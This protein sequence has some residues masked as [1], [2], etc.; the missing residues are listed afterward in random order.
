VDTL[1][2]CAEE[3]VALIERVGGSRGNPAA[4]GA[5]AAIG[6]P[7]DSSD[8]RLYP[9][10]LLVSQGWLLFLVRRGATKLLVGMVLKKIR[11]VSFPDIMERI[12]PGPSAQN[13]IIYVGPCSNANALYLQELVAHLR[14]CRNPGRPGFGAGDR[15]G[16][17][18]PGHVRALS[19][20][21]Y[22]PV[23][24]QQSIR[25]MDR[26]AR[27]PEDVMATAV[28]GMFQEGFSGAW[29]ADADHLKIVA[30]VERVATCPYTMF[31]L[32]PSD[33]IGFPERMTAGELREA[34]QQ[35][36]WAALGISADQLM[37]EYVG[38]EQAFTDRHGSYSA[39][40]RFDQD[41]VMRCAVKYGPGVA[42]CVE[43]AGRLQAER[44]GGFDLE[45]SFDETESPTSPLEHLFLASEFRR[46][47]VVVDS[48]ALRF[49]GGFEKGIDY[50]GDA[51][52]FERAFAV[53][54]AI[55]DH[56]GR[57]R[58][59]IHSG[60]DKF[61]IYPTMMKYA[62]DGLHVKTAGTTYLEALRVAASKTTALFGEILAFSFER[63]ERDRHSYHVSTDR[64]RLA[65]PE[66]IDPG[67][68]AALLDDDAWRQVLH[69]TFG[70][71]LTSGPEYDFRSRLCEALAADEEAFYSTLTGHMLK[72]LEAF[73]SSR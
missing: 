18:T 68:Y 64:A 36:P 1:V 54:A 26:T 8:F 53:H 65:K 66:A 73:E 14:P 38:R 19:S 17:S 33:V 39:T 30:D 35:L 50:T 62:G 6:A 10:S 31:T 12:E 52:T 43:L 22:F 29:G 42:R 20:S 24:A 21:R 16:L 56:F 59:S 34:F 47:G 70:S 15:I 11:A 69:V 67:R 45:V 28:W 57:Y 7:Y 3:V 4:C 5:L 61:S 41:G 9:N 37:V 55:K 63:Y 72:H 27:T 32:D 40:L 49:P 48:L 58:L 44:G 23:L 2:R 71:V 60:S 13:S 51:A 25:E 46:L